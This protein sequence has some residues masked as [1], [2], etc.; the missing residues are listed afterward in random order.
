MGL[1]RT[2]E[3][4]RETI[5]LCSG[6]VDGDKRANS[7][8]RAELFGIASSLL[9]ISSFIEFHKL[10]TTSMLYLWSDSAASL[11]RLHFLSWLVEASRETTGK[12]G[13]S[14]HYSGTHL[15]TSNICT[16][17]VD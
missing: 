13:Y 17:S 15:N 7:S 5:A 9:F 2:G 14:F 11:A 12:C 6:P 8:T 4:I 1:T 16:H 10:D 3:K